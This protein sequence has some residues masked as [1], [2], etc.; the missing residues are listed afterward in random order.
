M[1]FQEWEYMIIFIINECACR[2]KKKKRKN[3]KYMNAL[4]K[5]LLQDDRY[6]RSLSQMANGKCA[7][8]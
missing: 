4:N 6:Y 5:S 3:T 8:L 2:M 7:S 1:I